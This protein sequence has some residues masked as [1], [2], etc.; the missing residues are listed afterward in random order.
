MSMRLRWLTLLVPVL[1]VGGMELLS[2]S[3]FDQYLPFPADT[4][5]VSGVVLILAAVFSREAFRRIDRLGAELRARNRELE[6]RHASARA[7]HGV[8]V[9]IAALADLDAILQATVGSARRLLVAD[10]ALLILI[11]SDGEPVLRA[12]DGPAEAFDQ[13]GGQGGDEIRRFIHG[14]DRP[15]VLAAPLLR[16]G[17]TIGTLAVAGRSG[18][19]VDVDDIEMLSSLANQAAIAIENDRLDRE[20]RELAVRSERERIARE[21]HDG[22]AQ[23]L[24]YV[25]TKSQAVEEL[26]SAGRIPEA[27]GQMGE[28]A[29]AA[30]SIYVDVR[31]AILGLSVT[32]APEGGLVGAIEAYAR[33]FADAS[34]VAAEIDADPA[35]GQDALD[36]AVE[37][38]AFGV[39]REALTNVRKHADARRVAI[40]LRRT[41]E[42]LSIEVE[43]D[44][45]GFDPSVGAA[46]PGDFPHYGLVGMRERAAAVGGAVAWR[47]APGRGTTVRLSL[48]VAAGPVGSTVER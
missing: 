19:A 33:T 6:T 21:I 24:G 44:G 32:A 1:V 29:A 25:N 4:L 15:A 20:L 36:P 39:V 35:V 38:A 2:D 5:L 22:L 31:E 43:D 16:G 40:R 3:L 9:S 30:R 41:A 28:L 37:A 10:L 42:E 8:S 18:G 26:L 45:R 46:A 17:G 7:L 47:S 11:G 34:K 23:V 27:Q 13:A 12:A 14:S 48:P